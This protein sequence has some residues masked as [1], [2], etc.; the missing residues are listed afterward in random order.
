MKDD[1]AGQIIMTAGE[2]GRL[3]HDVS[4]EKPLFGRRRLF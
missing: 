1:T 2:F 4:D 3:L